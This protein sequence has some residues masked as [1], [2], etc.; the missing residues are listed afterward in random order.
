M[1]YALFILFSTL[2]L[3]VGYYFAIISNLLG[4]GGLGLCVVVWAVYGLIVTRGFG[5]GGFCFAFCMF[6]Y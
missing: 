5:W 1:L 2:F 3:F 4:F 6:I